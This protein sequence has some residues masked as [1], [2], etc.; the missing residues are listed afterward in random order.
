MGFK[1]YTDEERSAF[2]ELASEIG[3]TRAKRQLGFPHSWATGQRWVQAA[4][5]E[6][7]ID[8]IKAQ[9]A[10]AYDWYKAEEALVVAEEG[11][12]RAQ[13]TLQNAENLSADEQKKLS[14]AVQK[15]TNTWLLL[16]GKAN[17]ISEHHTKD[18]TDVELAQML[19]EERMRNALIESK[20]DESYQDL[21]T[22]DMAHMPRSEA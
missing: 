2:L 13:E 19:S 5:I 18:A 10:A 17:S 4:G 22:T 21:D 3:I 16:Q 11:L 8:E 9:A 1:E 14:E 6:I 7:P 20:E 15:Y 12:R